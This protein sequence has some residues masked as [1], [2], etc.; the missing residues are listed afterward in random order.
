MNIENLAKRL[1]S[2]DRVQAR[3][4]SNLTGTARA[5][6]TEGITR[7]L[8]ACD[9]RAVNPD[10]SALREI[11][12]DALRGRRVYAETG[13]EVEGGI[14]LEERKASRNVRRAKGKDEQE[15]GEVEVNI[16]A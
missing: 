7:H 4:F 14:T 12:D 10:T 11:I 16:D 3:H 6:A 13:Y 9:K 15:S 8:R 2:V 1:E 5:I